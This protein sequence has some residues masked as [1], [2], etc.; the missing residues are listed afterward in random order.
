MTVAVRPI[1]DEAIV[2]VEDDGVGIPR[3]MLEQ[4]FEPFVQLETSI[5]RGRQNGL[6]LGLA[7]A[8]SI[9]NLHGGSIR[10]SAGQQRAG[11][12]V[13]GAAPAQRLCSRLPSSEGSAPG[14]QAAP[15]CACSSSTT[16][17]TRRSRSACC[18]G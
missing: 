4:V 14:G 2:E 8:R 7:L 15:A 1:G 12:P 13:H 16:I 10:A 3:D 17:A 9:V 6:G 5:R 11:Q 18:S